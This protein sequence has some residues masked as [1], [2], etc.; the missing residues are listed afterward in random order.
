MFGV[1]GDAG[2]GEASGEFLLGFVHGKDAFFGGHDKLGSV[3]EI[4]ALFA[5]FNGKGLEFFCRE[6]TSNGGF[7]GVDTCPKDGVG[8]RAANRDNTKNSSD[9]GGVNSKVSHH[10]GFTERPTFFGVTK[11]DFARAN[12]A[13]ELFARGSN[14]DFVDN[15]DGWMHGRFVLK[16]DDVG[17]V[18]KLLACRRSVFFGVDSELGGGRELKE[19]FELFDEL[20]GGGSGAV[21]E[22]PLRCA[23][24]HG[25]I[26]LFAVG[27]NEVGNFVLVTEDVAI[28]IGLVKPSNFTVLELD[29]RVED[30]GIEP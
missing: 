20:V 3:L 29:A 7:F 28:I 8:R 10:V 2:F 13:N 22:D 21:D 12:V 17:H 9:D 16:K 5:F 1:A 27:R 30:F 6:G 25:P 18:F 26:G 23:T 14:F 4:L 15:F 19:I 24:G 11:N